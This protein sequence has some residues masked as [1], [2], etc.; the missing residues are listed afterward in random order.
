[1]R[2]SAVACLSSFERKNCQIA[3]LKSSVDYGISMREEPRRRLE[4]EKMASQIAKNL[5]HPQRFE[6]IEARKFKVCN[7]SVIFRIVKLMHE[8]VILSM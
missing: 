2:C 6:Q 5:A 8:K 3:Q 1:M 7:L 4:R